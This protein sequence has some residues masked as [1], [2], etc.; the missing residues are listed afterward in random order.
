M[1]TRDLSISLKVLDSLKSLPDM[2]DK[3]AEAASEFHSSVIATTLKTVPEIR[4]LIEQIQTLFS[5]DGG[6]CYRQLLPRALGEWT[7]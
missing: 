1:L 7:D 2:F 4:P 3:L 6:K 5:V